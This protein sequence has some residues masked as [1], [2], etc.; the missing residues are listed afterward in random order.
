MKQLYLNQTRYG[1]YCNQLKSLLGIETTAL[2]MEPGIS[3][4]LQSAKIPIRD[5]NI[6]AILGAFVSGNCNQ[7]KSLLGIETHRSGNRPLY[8][9]DCNQLKSLLG[10]E[11][12]LIRGIPRIRINCNQL[13]SL[14]GIETNLPIIYRWRCEYCNQLKSLLGIETSALGI[15]N[16]AATLQ[17]AKI[18]IRDWNTGLNNMQQLT[19]YCNQ[20]KSLL[21]IETNSYY[22]LKKLPHNDCNQLKSLLGIET[23][24]GQNIGSLELNCNQLKSLLG[25]ETYNKPNT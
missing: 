16:A 10:I 8:H 11:T 23:T 12:F 1:Q 7:L 13:K 19:L 15:R 2:P 20:L 4:K 21:G 24:L 5:W 22:D 14:L 6:L 3:W 25:I 18:P 9:I 17:S